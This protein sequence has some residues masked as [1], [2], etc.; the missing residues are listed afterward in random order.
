MSENVMYKLFNCFGFIATGVSYARLRI[1]VVIN[2]KITIH[3]DYNCDNSKH[4]SVPIISI[5]F[6]KMAVLNYCYSY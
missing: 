1:P 3:S 6:I 4:H 5:F 2:E